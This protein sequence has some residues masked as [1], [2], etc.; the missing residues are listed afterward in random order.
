M[1]LAFSCSATGPAAAEN[2]PGNQDYLI[3]VWGAS[4]G[5]PVNS[6]TDVAQT[7]EHYLWAG[8][9]LSG[10]LRFD[11]VRFVPFHSRNT[12]E[13]TGMGVRRLMADRTGP[14]W[15]S[16]YEGSLATWEP[17]G[18]TLILTNVGRPDTLLWSQPGHAR[19]SFGDGTFLEVART[20][21]G[22]QS[23]TLSLSD[24]G[25][26]ANLCADNEGRIWAWR[27]EH[28]LGLWENGIL[29]KL[30]PPPGLEQIKIWTISA[31]AHGNIWAGTDRALLKWDTDHFVNLTPTNRLGGFPVNHI[32]A[33]GES[34]WVESRG[35]LLR[36]A[37]GNVVA[38]AGDWNTNF[39][40]MN[41]RFRR[42]DQQGG[43]WAASDNLGL[44]HVRGDGTWRIISTR[45]GLPSNAIRN[46][47]CDAEGNAWIGYE[48]GGLVQ[49]RQ[50]LFQ[51]IGREQGLGDPL[52]NSVCEDAEGAV[53]IG[54]A[55]K[56][57][58][59]FKDGRCTNYALPLPAGA[60]EMIVTVDSA[61]RIWAGCFGGGLMHFTNGQFT[62]VIRAEQLPGYLRL[63]LPARDGRL[64]IGTLNS[65]SVVAGDTVT[66]VYSSGNSIARPAALAETAEGTIWA[67]TFDGQLLRWDGFKFISQE[68]PDHRELG[69]LWSLC[70]TP[71][72][73]LWIGSSEG[74]LLRFKDG[75]FHRL[76]TRNGLRSDFIVQTL[77]DRARN[78]WLVTGAGVEKITATAL[79]RFERGELTTL[80]VSQ[81][82]RSDGLV[83]LGGSVEFQPNCG[84]GRDGRLWFA[85][86]S[87]VAGVQPENVRANPVSPTVVIE[88]LRV[89]QNRIW[90]SNGAMV[91]AVSPIAA[92]E[93]DANKIPRANIAPGYHELEFHFTGLSFHAPSLLKFKYQ[94][95]GFETEWHEAGTERW[96]RY[97]SPPPGK[98]VF[99]LMAANSDDVWNDHC[100]E[101]ALEL[102]PFFYQ[103]AWFQWAAGG[104]GAAILALAVWFA[105]RRRM[106]RRL[107]Q[108]AHQRE[109]ERDRARIAKD[110]HDEI[111]A[112][113]TRISYMSE[114]AKQNQTAP[115]PVTTQIDAIAE[116]SR[117]L[118]QSLDEIVWAVNPQNDTL[119]HLAAYLGHYANEYFQN[120]SVDCTIAMPP[121]LPHQPITSEARHNLYLAFEESLTNVLKHAA[122]QRVRIEMRLFPLTFEITIA[123][124]GKGM[125]QSV[126]KSDT[127]FPSH[128]DGLHNMRQRL[129]DIGGHF[130]VEG[131]PG[132][133]TTIRLTIPLKPMN[134]RN[135]L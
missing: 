4:E 83:D 106:K 60:R 84:R 51:V 77:L 27:G 22:W 124:D 12:P 11:G 90:P 55:G 15:I 89:N 99:R 41:F 62:P 85:L 97:H 69:R 86:G 7:P 1:W 98:Y 102:E 44:I 66:P 91:F 40:A 107:E 100:A 76:T 56:T 24:A 130:I 35:E 43:Y 58:S 59:Q 26:R 131:G 113:L 53:W 116:T 125:S 112:K 95:A 123:D 94:L 45:D 121:Q 13:L 79:A 118:L 37:N 103:T 110:M 87:S 122:A 101:L 30:S 75:K 133:G 65:I 72:G 129:A 36:F 19:F 67:G 3:T 17:S 88:E 114:L 73:G 33:A 42:G 134:G 52:V 10:L 38:E 61:N 23:Q 132:A 6:I 120:T 2:L 39:A 20:G 117:D 29:R 96:A 78:L 68:V 50:R 81:Y 105:A 111:G 57:V 128:A 71:D 70:A 32:V 46:I 14:L 54:T 82:S 135:P 9:L 80:P 64:W 119:E 49:V 34:L 18:F 28:E 8:T 31:D 25:A 74:G 115:E 109:L 126:G 92:A 108:L 93:T 104:S 63:M 21:G 5:L 127:P 16:T 48:R 47:F